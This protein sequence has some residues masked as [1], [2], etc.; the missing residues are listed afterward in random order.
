MSDLE[1]S[2]KPGDASPSNQV[3]TGALDHV[4]RSLCAGDIVAA[5]AGLVTVAGLA[6]ALGNVL[7]AGEAYRIKHLLET[8][9]RHKAEVD[10]LL[11][12]LRFDLGSRAMPLPLPKY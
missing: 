2:R 11:G 9:P 1:S 12:Q 6:M 4:E 10:Y 3:V 5:A 8:W 7:A